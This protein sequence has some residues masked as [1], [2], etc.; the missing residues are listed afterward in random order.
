MKH[1]LPDTLT[2]IDVETT[3]LSPVHDRVIEIGAV[4]LEKGKKVAVFESFVNPHRPLPPE[5]TRI[6]GI[7][8]GHLTDAPD[9]P[10]I[11]RQV[12]ELLDGSVLVA[13]NAGFDYA[14]LSEEFKRTETEFSYPSLCT[15]RLF[16]HLYPGLRSYGLDSLISHFG[17]TIK[18]RHRALGDAMVLVAFLKHAKKAANGMMTE[19]VAA[20]TGSIPVPVYVGDRKTNPDNT[21]G[22]YTF[23]AGNGMP[24]YIGK[25]VKVRS[26]LLSHFR[27]HLG[28]SKQI[29]HQTDHIAVTPLPGEISALITEQYLI[30]KLKPLHNRA[31]RITEP[32]VLRGGKDKRGYFRFFIETLPASPDIGETV[33]GPF[34]SKQKAT[35]YVRV[36]AAVHNLCAE[37]LLGKQPKRACLYHQLGECS[38]ACCGK[39]SPIK[40]M[41]AVITAFADKKISSW[42]YPDTVTITE[43]Q[44]G[45]LARFTV[46]NWIIE[47]LESDRPIIPESELGKFSF[48]IYSILRRQL[49]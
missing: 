1:G 26:R 25:S 46:N 5:I 8:A 40:F 29:L 19:A 42:P 3:G 14:F 43:R 4:R 20:S 13:H 22:V 17:I 28:I 44:N 9:F 2:I 16:R 10:D 18:N 39:V 15:V 30:K 11:K 31:L 27:S 49:R 37:V 24:L 32:Y 23:I 21:P 34:P 35:E 7:T 33:Y 41:M 45:M 47:A 36:T 38:G 6:T 48:D 12:T